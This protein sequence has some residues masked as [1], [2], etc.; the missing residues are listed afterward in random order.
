VG[1]EYIYPSELLLLG[2]WLGG[3][4]LVGGLA[5]QG[6]FLWRKG[7][8][9]VGRRRELVAPILASAFL[10]YVLTFVFWFTL[11]REL[12]WPTM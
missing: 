11:P 10:G 8:G 4:A 9:R 12:D 2:L 5:V 3:P 6:V 1:D 7:L